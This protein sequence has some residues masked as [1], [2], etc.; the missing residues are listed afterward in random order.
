ME[1][2]LRCAV[3]GMGL[4][5]SQHAEHLYKHKNTLVTAVCDQKVEKAKRWA[6]EHACSWY[7]D[8]TEMYK[9]EKPDLVVVAT[10]DPYHKGPILKACKSGI[11]F[12]ISEKP[13]TT[14]LA[15]ACEIREAAKKSGTCIKVL[16][17]NRFYP[18]DRSIRLLVYPGTCGERTAGIFL[19]S[20][21]RHSSYSAMR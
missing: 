10:Q 5:G 17:P 19:R 18:L 9:K 6:E 20:L 4:L 15:D 14:S 21:L 2:I 13:L 3:V 12:V 8:F 1:K 11:P 16:F 7:E